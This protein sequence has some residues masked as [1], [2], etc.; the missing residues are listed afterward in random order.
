MAFWCYILRCADGK[1]YTGHTDDLDRRIAEH[2]QGGYCAFTTKRRP[3]ELVWCADFPT[4]IEAIEA[5]VQVGKWSRAKKEAMIAR[6]WERVAYFARAPHERR[7]PPPRQ[8]VSTSLDTNG[9][10]D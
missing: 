8:G 6:D 1:Y 7:G 5:E 2:Q 9:G 4:R 3:I 10:G